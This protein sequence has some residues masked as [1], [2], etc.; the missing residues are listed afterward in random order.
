MILNAYSCD[1]CHKKIWGKPIRKVMYGVDIIQFQELNER[2]IDLCEE[3]LDSLQKWFYINSI[4]NERVEYRI[5]NYQSKYLIHKD[6]T[7]EP[8]EKFDGEL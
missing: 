8:K 1:R 3:C 6:G 4:M 5:D 7:I 2:H